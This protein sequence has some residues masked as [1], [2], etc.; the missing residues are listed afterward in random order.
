M[1]TTG[2]ASG[3]S[4]GSVSTTNDA[5]YRPAASLITATDDGTEGRFR[6]HRTGTSPI[7]GSRSLPPRPTE[8][9]A[10]RV[11]RITW[12]RSLRDRNRGCA[13]FGPG[14]CPVAEAKKLRYAAFKVH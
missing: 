2:S 13:I 11:T 6:D 7:L 4:S 1:P 14:R 12:R 8:K 10:L 5:K 3:S 9:P